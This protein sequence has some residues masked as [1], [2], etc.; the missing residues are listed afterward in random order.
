[1]LRV[2]L[3]PMMSA[4][5]LRRMLT[6]CSSWQAKWSITTTILWVQLLNRVP[7]SP[8]LMNSISLGSGLTIWQEKNALGSKRM[9]QRMMVTI[10]YLGT[11]RCIKGSL[12]RMIAKSK[13]LEKPG[14]KLVRAWTSLTQTNRS[15]RSRKSS[16]KNRCRLIWT[17]CR[18]TG[19]LSWLCNR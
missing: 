12:M 18:T 8:L 4:R 1:M 9:L 19:Y 3:R 5:T 14:S 2:S 11:C 17:H 13:L 16:P 6:S 15:E 10:Q 7:L